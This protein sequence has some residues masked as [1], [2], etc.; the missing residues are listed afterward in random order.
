MIALRKR[1][2]I[3]SKCLVVFDQNDTSDLGQSLNRYGGSFD[4]SMQWVLFSAFRKNVQLSFT[5]YC[6]DWQAYLQN[7][8]IHIIERKAAGLKSVL[9]RRA[10]V[11][12]S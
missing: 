2:E 1:A 9:R 10:S 8:Q 11:L 12:L 5:K 4:E 3:D 7:Y 6:K